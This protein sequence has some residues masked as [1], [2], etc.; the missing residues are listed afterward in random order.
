MGQREGVRNYCCG[1][2]LFEF[3][4]EFE[5]VQFWLLKIRNNLLISVRYVN[6]LSG[7]NI[8]DLLAHK[9]IFAS[10]VIRIWQAERA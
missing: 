10:L 4:D 1:Q 6:M 9:S 2:N 8:I 3:V 5:P 7:V